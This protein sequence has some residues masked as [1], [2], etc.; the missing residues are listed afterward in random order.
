MWVLAERQLLSWGEKTTLVFG[1][2]NRTFQ[3]QT[4]LGFFS[5]MFHFCAV[6]KQIV[7]VAATVQ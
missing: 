5:G 2:N 6:T 1:S 4:S 7:S 3:D